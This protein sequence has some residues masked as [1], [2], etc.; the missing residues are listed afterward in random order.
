MQ[1]RLAVRSKNTTLYGFGG[2]VLGGFFGTSRF[3]NMAGVF[4]LAAETNSPLNNREPWNLKEIQ[5]IVSFNNQDGTSLII[6][7]DDAADTPN[8]TITVLTLQT[9]E[10]STGEITE[11]IATDSE[12]NFEADLTG[13]TAGTLFTI[14]AG[15]TEINLP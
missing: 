7:R 5:M 10:F 14:F 2:V 9:G 3:M 4:N 15:C 1:T 12:V 13:S 8:A 11:P 6:F